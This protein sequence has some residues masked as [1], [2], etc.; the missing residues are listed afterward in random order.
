MSALRKFVIFLAILVVTIPL[1]FAGVIYSKLKMMHVSGDFD[2]LS[3][4]KYKYDNSITNILMIG[5]DAR[6]GEEISRSDSMMILT[7]D[8]KNKSLKLTSLGRDTYVNIPG[9]GFE[10]LTHSYAYGQEKLLIETIEEN[11]KLDIQNYAKVDFFS[12]ME[13]V[14]TI[15]GIDVN[16]NENEINEMNKF[17]AEC[18]S[19]DK[20][21]KKGKLQYI[22]KSGNQKLKG[23]QAL[24]YARIRKSDGTMQR[25]NRQRLVIEAILKKVNNMS[26]TKYPKLLDAILPYVETNMKPTEILGLGREVLSFGDLR[27]NTMQFPLH[28][29][30]EVKLPK[31]GYVIPFEEYELQFLHSFI[32]DNKKPTKLEIQNA[33]DRWKNSGSNSQYSNDLDYSSSSQ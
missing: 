11:F 24:T 15:G 32:F 19:W 9:H 30:N 13:I 25:D 18:Y 10:K 4:N 5:S 12:F 26:L 1:V 22:T 7:V 6:P 3:T 21:P 27:L 31:A 8:G 17:I 29:E 23:Y 33:E 20:N 16:I 2:I 14:D 28:P